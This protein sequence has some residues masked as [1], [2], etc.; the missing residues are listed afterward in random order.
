MITYQIDKDD[1]YLEELLV[2]LRAHNKSFTG[3]K[4]R[5]INYIYVVKNNQL[6]SGATQLTERRDSVYGAKRLHIWSEATLFG[7][8]G[9]TGHR[10]LW[11][12]LPFFFH[13]FCQK[14]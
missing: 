7:V 6:E 2:H 1:K 11:G 9:S 12:A 10:I 4:T 5:E 3:E 13:M 14:M 8:P